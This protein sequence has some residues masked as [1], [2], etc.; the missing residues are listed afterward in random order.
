[1]EKK[2]E[3]GEEGRS[4]H[5]WEYAK[6]KKNWGGW[7]GMEEWSGCVGKGMRYGDDGRE[8]IDLPSE[9]T[10]RDWLVLLSL[11]LLLLLSSIE[12]MRANL[13]QFKVEE[14]EESW[15]DWELRRNMQTSRLP[16]RLTTIYKG[17]YLLVISDFTPNYFER[18]CYLI[19]RH[20]LFSLLRWRYL[21]PFSSLSLICLRSVR[22]WEY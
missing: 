12:V 20:P 13:I 17:R 22:S 10:H 19:V 16:P 21:L 2:K 15:D 14:R 7:K 3:E 11:I 4:S 1:M 18:I 5:V 8:W 6:R 9:C